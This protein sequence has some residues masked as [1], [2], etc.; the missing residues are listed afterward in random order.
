MAVVPAPHVVARARLASQGLLPG[1]GPGHAAGPADAVRRLLLVQAQDLGQA[2][3]ALGVRAPGAGAAKVRAA[4]DAGA[5]V[6]TW[7]AR[8]TLMLAAPGVLDDVLAVTA[9]RMRALAAAGFRR[10]GITAGDLA[11]LEPVALRRSADGATRNELLEAFRDAGQPTS[12][13]RGYHLLMGLSLERVIVQGPMAAGGSRQLFVPYRDW[14]GPAGH[15]GGIA[16][17]ALERLAV[18]YFTGHGPAT[19]PTSPGGSA[20]R[21]PPCAPRWRRPGPVGG[22]CAGTWPAPATGWGLR[23]RPCSTGAGQARVPAA[24]SPC[25]ASTSTCSDTATGRPPCRRSMRPGWSPAATG[26]SAGPSSRQGRRSAPGRPGAGPSPLGTPWG[27]PPSV[28]SLRGSVSMPGFGNGEVTIASRC[29]SP[30]TLPAGLSHYGCMEHETSLEHALDLAEGNIKEAKRLL[31]RGKA[32][33]AAGEITDERLAALQR[34]YDTAHE[35]V[36]RVQHEN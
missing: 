34:L 23:L 22:W 7:A 18:G 33:H 15:D 4:F 21:W 32:A 16:E 14:L 11:A 17:G 26:S 10:S 12:G 35:D 25:P 28:P 6:R 36:G 29:G 31:D 30:W 20:S 27:L 5:I 3:W 19:G 1:P 2:F 13:Q 24:S 8:G 9:P